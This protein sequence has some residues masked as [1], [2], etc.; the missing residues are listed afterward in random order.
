MDSRFH[1]I[2]SS[3]VHF[4]GVAKVSLEMSMYKFMRG[5][6]F[7]TTSSAYWICRHRHFM[8]SEIRIGLGGREIWEKT[9]RLEEAAFVRKRGRDQLLVE[10]L[11]QAVHSTFISCLY[12][13]LS[14]EVPRGSSVACV[15]EEKY[16]LFAWDVTCFSSVGWSLRKQEV[17]G[18]Y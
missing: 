9:S 2:K 13:D 4:S 18:I 11:Y 7:L 3:A 12:G 14:W 15:R 1:P 5:I 8:C 17:G 10:V 16:R 6:I